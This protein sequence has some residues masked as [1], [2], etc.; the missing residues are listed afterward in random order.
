M[1]EN[2]SF[3]DIKM[4]LFDVDGVMTDGTIYIGDE[5]E[6]FKPFNAKDG[7]AIELLR[8]HGLITGVISGKSSRALDYRCRQLK[9]DNIITG[10]KNKLPALDAL[11]EKYKIK[12]NQVA[13]LG[14]DVLDI[15]IFDAVGLAVAPSD[16]H[17]LALCSANWVTKAS[18]GR[19]MVREFVDEFLQERSG[20]SLKEIYEPLFSKIILGDTN[21][22][23]Q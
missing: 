8:V 19:A 12:R 5:G 10:C 14:D 7:I 4:I 13:F 15:P 3:P 23:E 17:P 6:I 22:L 16:A 11:C 2:N 1:F 21:K 9:F 20:C 18:G